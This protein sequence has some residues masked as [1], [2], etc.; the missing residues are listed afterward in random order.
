MLVDGFSDVRLGSKFYKLFS[1]NFCEFFS[2]ISSETDLE[3]KNLE[4]LKEIASL[5][6]K[7]QMF[8]QLR[9]ENQELK[10]ILEFRFNYPQ[11]II[12]AEITKKTPEEVN[13][14]YMVGK[15]VSDG[16]KKNATVIS[17]NG[18]VG[19][20]LKTNENTSVIQT[21]KNYNSA[22]S[23]R[24]TRSKTH[25]IL[26]WNKKFFIE[27]IPQYADIKEGD[28]IVTSGDGSVFPRGLPVGIVISVKKQENDFSLDTEVK[29]FDD[30]DKIDVVFIIRK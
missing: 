3:R 6:Y 18:L 30:L 27:G 13:L 24:D 1:F 4:L 10:K 17:F 19:K 29:T 22:V 23:I 11:F 20:V 12:P 14:S 28:T 16:I 25:G 8:D 7:K 9:K 26:K 5:S 2:K 21:L 15:G